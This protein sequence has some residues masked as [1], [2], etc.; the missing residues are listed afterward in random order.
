MILI[1]ATK[2][3]CKPNTLYL[4]KLSWYQLFS[5]IDNNEIRREVVVA[6][7]LEELESQ[8]KKLQDNIIKCIETNNSI[9]EAD[10]VKIKEKSY[11]EGWVEG[12][13]QYT[14]SVN[15]DKDSENA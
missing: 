15:K 4:D 12:I 8:A 10:L 9:I 7:T 1:L 2:P 3:V 13:A 11:N 5:W 14:K 6:D